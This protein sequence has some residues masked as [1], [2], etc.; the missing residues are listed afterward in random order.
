MFV[1]ESSSGIQKV[2]GWLFG[3]RPEF[4]DPRIVAQAEGREGD[5]KW[6]IMRYFLTLFANFVSVS[7]TKVRTQGF[8]AIS[9]N[10]VIKDLKKLGYDVNPRTLSVVSEFPLQLPLITMKPSVNQRTDANGDR[11]DSNKEQKTNPTQSRPVS[12]E[13]TKTAKGESHDDDYHDFDRPGPSTSNGTNLRR[14][15]TVD[16]APDELISSVEQLN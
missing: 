8:V 16:E 6:T 2:A 14:M 3:R 5:Q 13:T 9:W 7:V 11:S 15:D 10:I 12:A 4:I 1:P